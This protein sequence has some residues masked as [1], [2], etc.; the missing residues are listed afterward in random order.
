MTVRPP[1]LATRDQLAPTDEAEEK[2]IPLWPGALA[3]TEFFDKPV[4]P[5][6]PWSA[7]AFPE[8]PRVRNRQPDAAWSP[9]NNARNYAFGSARVRP[10][11]GKAR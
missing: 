10:G 9:S 6:E 1:R 3:T 5:E 2:Y 4:E 11:W 8:R 7:E